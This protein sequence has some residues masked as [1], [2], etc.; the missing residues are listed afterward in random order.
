MI[1]NKT[2]YTYNDLTIVPA[3]VSEVVSRQDVNVYNADGFLPVFTAP[4]SAVI[5]EKNYECFE[6]VDIHAVL[7]T[8]VPLKTRLKLFG[9]GKWCAFSMTECQDIMSDSFLVF[10]KEQN[11]Y[12]VQYKICIDVANGH[13]Q[14]LFNLAR[15]LKE[16]FSEN[17]MKLTIMSGNIANPEALPFYN[18]LI[19]LARVGIGGGSGC[20]TTS[21][22][23][24]HYPL[25]SLINDCRKIINDYGLSVKLIAD[26][27]IRNYSDAIKALALGADYV[28]IGGLFTQT[29][30]SA[31]KEY[32]EDWTPIEI[33]SS[34]KKLC[35]SNDNEKLKRDF[36]KN[37]KVFHEIYGMSTKRAQQERGLKHL[38][39]SEGTSHL[40]PVKYT[41]R[42][43]TTN[44]KDYLKSAMSYCNKKQLD[45]FIGNVTLIPNSSASINGVNK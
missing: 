2:G 36:I 14:Q 41:L 32:T 1:L 25:A 39:T 29:L 45:N 9:L 40:Y 5:D 37:Y 15:N 12:P 31:S 11:F 21:N 27:G 23:G 34:I 26:G 35:M 19:D 18:G 30:E 6:E 10:I 44:F 7:P 22:T 16:F 43:W 38:K 3:P 17:K 24:V 33:N 20:I 42:Q 4:M 28:M 8:T 13:M